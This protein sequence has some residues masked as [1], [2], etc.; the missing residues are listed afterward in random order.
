MLNEILWII[1]DSVNTSGLKFIK[2]KS[3]LSQSLSGNFPIKNSTSRENCESRAWWISALNTLNLNTTLVYYYSNPHCI[4]LLLLSL[5]L[6]SMSDTM[7]ESS[8]S[9]VWELV[10]GV[11]SNLMSFTSHI[12]CYRVRKML[13]KINGNTNLNKTFLD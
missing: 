3:L 7:P 10:Q 2:I 4:L 1:W 12:Q 11:P 13:K 8:Q 5:L 9:T 6:T